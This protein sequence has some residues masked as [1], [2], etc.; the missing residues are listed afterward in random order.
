M[1]GADWIALLNLIPVEQHN[2]LNIITRTG[3]EL[4]V[5]MFLRMEATYLVFR[6]R[7]VGNTDEG[8][9]FFTPYSE[10]A[11]IYINRYVKETEISQLFSDDR[12]PPL[13]AELLSGAVLDDESA[14]T[15]TDR[16][17]A[18]TGV[19]TTTAPTPLLI[20]PVPGTGSGY[21]P[22]VGVGAPPRTPAAATV[23][24]A[25]AV[26]RATG[27][28]PPPPPAATADVDTPPPKGSIL[29]RLRAQRNNGKS[30]G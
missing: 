28:I 10:I 29:E 8:R 19:P 27:F 2:Q 14:L 22:R 26:T 9:V 18:P 30:G 16:L 1:T 3:I 21:V 20:P 23:G 12:S 17:P 13:P 7:M 15:R 24:P 25:S 11:S 5:D 6:G 4:S